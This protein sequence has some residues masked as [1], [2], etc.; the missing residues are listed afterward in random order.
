MLIL[1]K[2]FP[3]NV[4]A[5]DRI[6]ILKLRNGKKSCLEKNNNKIQILSFII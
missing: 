4:S 6:V 1:L 3:R 2:S 5:K